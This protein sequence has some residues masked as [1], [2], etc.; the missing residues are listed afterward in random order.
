MANGQLFSLCLCTSI[1]GGT[2]KKHMLW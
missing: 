2:P 1:V